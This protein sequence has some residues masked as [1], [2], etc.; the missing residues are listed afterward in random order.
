[1]CWLMTCER[2]EFIAWR[3]GGRAGPRGA[4]A[5]AG[6]A[7]GRVYQRRVGRCLSGRLLPMTARSA[8]LRPLARACGARAEAAADAENCRPVGHPGIATDGC[9]AFAGHRSTWRCNG[10]G[11][12]KNELEKIDTKFVHRF[13]PTPRR[14]LEGGIVHYTSGMGGAPVRA[15]V[16]FRRLRTSKQRFVGCPTDRV[17]ALNSRPRRRDGWPDRGRRDQ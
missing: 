2:G 5:A 16:S 17:F 4:C 11:P 10:D 12:F 6:V 1:L 14:K 3:R 8:H 7:G 15:Y 13:C 9:K